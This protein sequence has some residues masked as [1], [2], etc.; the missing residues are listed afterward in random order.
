M[1]HS[2]CDGCGREGL[3]ASKVRYEVKIEVKAAYDRLA[4]ND[5]DL[6]RDYRA[7]IAGVLAELEGLSTEE[8]QNQVY[9]VFDFNLC[10]SCQRRYIGK[11]VSGIF[12]P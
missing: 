11:L 1:N 5:E 12:V 7:E 8:A 4:L 3:N 9:R 2:I 10:L 6:Q